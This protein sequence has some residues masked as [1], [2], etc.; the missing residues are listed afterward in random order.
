MA[1]L[2]GSTP[3]ELKREYEERKAQNKLD[4]C[5]DETYYEY[6]KEVEPLITDVCG[7]FIK[8]ASNE[9]SEHMT[10]E[11]DALLN[12]ILVMM[13]IPIGSRA[14]TYNRIMQ[15]VRVNLWTILLGQ[16]TVAAKTSTV[17]RINQ[18]VLAGLEGVLRAKYYEEKTQ[19]SQLEAKEKANTSAPRKKNIKAGQG[20]SFQGMIKELNYNQ[21][22]LLY[23]VQEAIVLMER[24][25][26]S[27]DLKGE[28]V[29]LYDDLHYGKALVGSEGKGE[30]TDIMRPFVSILMLSTPDT[31]YD[32]LKKHD[33]T[34]GYMN[35]F[36]F[37]QI[38]EA[39]P[40]NSMNNTKPDFKKFQDVSIRV[41][42]YLSNFDNNKPFEMLLTDEAFTR[43]VEWD[44]SIRYLD[45]DSAYYESVNEN[46]YNG[47]V[48]RIKNKVFKYALIVQVYD[49]F[50]EG[51]VLH[52][53]SKISLKYINFAIT[54]AEN[55][56]KNVRGI[57]QNHEEK[58][59]KKSINYGPEIKDEYAQ[60]V[61]NFIEN[62]QGHKKYP[63][64]QYELASRIYELKHNKDI[65]GQV[66]KIAVEKY[67]IVCE[68]RESRG[69]YYDH[70]SYPS[71]NHEVPNDYETEEY[72]PN[73]I[74]L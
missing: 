72:D 7:S 49:C 43:Y 44:D 51:K 60:K 62:N 15:E 30:V 31:F 24:M 19:Y 45:K 11:P 22:G 69:R 48:S 26:K 65:V 67:G 64:K 70:Y 12:V 18:L 29:S 37:Y 25:N 58:F 66:L 56:I 34:S 35:R 41:W 74:N 36:T 21:H 6:Q 40:R 63:F 68:S 33:F 9:I 2:D 59:A 71:Y 61:Y 28:L 10:I 20:S 50:Y 46:S 14:I 39:V 8:D 42:E 52:A 57:L 47:S 4:E 27:Q 1:I 13:S 73:E 23:T 5:D 53:D 54:I 3:E 38:Q 32:S 16:T 55:D 17:D